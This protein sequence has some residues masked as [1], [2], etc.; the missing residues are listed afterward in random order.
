[1]L[2]R[3]QP[4]LCKDSA[5][6]WNNQRL[7]IIFHFLFTLF[8]NIQKLIIYR[9]RQF[10]LYYFIFH[11]HKGMTVFIVLNA[12]SSIWGIYSD[13]QKAEEQRKLADLDAGWRGSNNIYRVAI[14]KV[15]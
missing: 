9:K 13:F 5:N 7:C 3:V 6:K 10:V 11:S 12:E 14:Q 15:Q 2:C 8:N 4:I 1:M